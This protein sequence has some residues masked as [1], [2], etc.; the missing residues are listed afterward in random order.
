MRWLM[1]GVE[2]YYSVKVL[3]RTGMSV[4]KISKALRISTTTVQKLLNKNDSEALRKLSKVIR[5]SNFDVAF[6]FID[7]TLTSYPEMRSSKL[8][9]KVLEEYTD[10]SCGERAFRNYISKIRSNYGKDSKRRYQPIMT[11]RPGYQVQVDPGEKKIVLE[12]GEVIK[13]YFVAFV[14]CFSR[15]K[16][17]YIQNRPF[18][19]GDFIRAHKEAF[20]YFGGIAEEYI[21]DQTKLVAIKE[22]FREVW[23]NKEFHQFAVE[24]G[25]TPNVCEGYDPESKGKVERVV[26]EIKRDF[27]YGESFNTLEDIRDESLLWLTRVNSTTHSTTRKSP[28]VLFAEERSLLKPYKPEN[29][30]EKRIVDKTGLIS[31]KGNKYSVPSAYQQKIV[32]I[33]FENR[34]LIV[35]DMKTG[36]MITT[37]KISISKGEQI[38]N[39]NHYRNYN[40]TV[41]KLKEKCLERL[42]FYDKAELMIE[43][44]VF[45]NPKIVRD[46]LR[47]ILSLYKHNTNEDWQKIIN[48]SLNLTDLR[49]SVL[50]DIIEKIKKQKQIKE[51]NVQNNNLWLKHAKPSSS[52]LDRS[53]AKYDEVLS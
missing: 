27:L 50:S 10:I 17:L 23:F 46:Q 5:K 34:Y 2:V 30:P 41:E 24:S 44:I 22:Q 43:K 12:S 15:M 49:I 11:D 39:T 7:A 53:L 16:Y 13:V 14:F 38:I 25:F 6:D 45:D 48:F 32:L 35:M 26:Q 18:N 19:T 4:R 37:H 8:Y 29:E 36:N 52:I 3:N 31:Y 47:G 33:K 42:K 51:A 28:S 20:S 1:K 9:R 21:Y 40:D